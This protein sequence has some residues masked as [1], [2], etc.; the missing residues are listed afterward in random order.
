MSFSRSAGAKHFALWAAT[1]CC[2]CQPGALSHPD[3]SEIWIQ[4]TSNRTIRIWKKKMITCCRMEDVIN[5]YY[6]HFSL[7]HQDWS[8]II[9]FPCNT[10]NFMAQPGDLASYGRSLM[11]NVYHFPSEVLKAFQVLQQAKQIGV[12]EWKTS[13]RLKEQQN[14]QYTIWEF[15]RFGVTSHRRYEK[16]SEFSRF[17]TGDMM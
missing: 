8:F 3:I 11:M 2:H 6:T 7:Q 15:L 1:G 16:A 10:W 4:L 14:V 12:S 13:M 5:S 9:I 17:D